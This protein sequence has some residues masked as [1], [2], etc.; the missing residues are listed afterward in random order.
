MSIFLNRAVHFKV[1]C[2]YKAFG[3]K[4]FKFRCKLKIFGG[5]LKKR[6]TNVE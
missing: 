2:I 4:K 5:I 1:G 6:V 3:D